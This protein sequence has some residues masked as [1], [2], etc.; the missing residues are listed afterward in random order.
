M[1]LPREGVTP[2]PHWSV[3]FPGIADFNGMLPSRFIPDNWI[4]LKYA[5]VP[6]RLNADT[7]PVLVPAG[8]TASVLASI[9]ESYDHYVLGAG[10][11]AVA[12]EGANAGIPSTRYA[13]DC[14]QWDLGAE[15]QFDSDQVPVGSVFGSGEWPHWYAIPQ[16][17][18]ANTTWNVDLFSRC[19]VE[20][21]I[22]IEFWCLRKAVGTSQQEQYD[23]GANGQ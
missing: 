20:V 18:S 10:A 14:R 16:V 12:T 1:R 6:F 15:E 5:G 11:F 8:G 23:A 7:Y 4:N 22:F 2:G 9:K 13:L 17:W 19:S 3:I 21:A